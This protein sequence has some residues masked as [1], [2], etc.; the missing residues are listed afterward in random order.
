MANNDVLVSIIVPTYN[1][2]PYIEN[3][4]ASL[5]AQDY[6]NIEIIVVDDGSNDGTPKK[7]E[8]INDSRIRVLRLPHAGV[9]RARNAGIEAANGEYIIFI[10]GDD[11]V[12]PH[13][14]S[15]LVGGLDRKA[16]CSMIQ[17]QIDFIDGRPSELDPVSSAIYRN[18]TFIGKEDFAILYDNYLLSSPCNKIYKT[19][20]IKDNDIRFD[21][22][23]SYAEDLVFNLQYFRH[24]TCVRMIPAATYHYIKYPASSS[25]RFHLNTAYTLEKI[26][27]EAAQT[28]K[29]PTDDTKLIFLK[30]IMW[31]L[32]NVSNTKSQLSSRDAKKEIR[33][34]LHLPNYDASLD[35]LPRLGINRVLGLL[36]R[37]KSA[38]LIY[39][40]LHH[41]FSK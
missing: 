34:I 25:G 24:I 15:T 11:M 28:I 38:N 5:Q 6:G 7:A 36:L 2:A 21:E 17:M 22:K 18:N 41:R 10:D 32:V 31:G 30:H 37:L 23:I 12:E 29:N 14:V 8:N 3:C 27:N 16:D 33:Q 4:I 20:I 39:Q 40:A 35:A 26:E 9:S 1:A 19:R 13:H